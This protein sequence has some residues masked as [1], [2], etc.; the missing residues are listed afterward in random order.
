MYK[1]TFD[2]HSI[3]ETNSYSCMMDGWPWTHFKHVTKQNSC[4]ENCIINLMDVT[5]GFSQHT[6]KHLLTSNLNKFL[7]ISLFVANDLLN[8]K[9]HLFLKSNDNFMNIFLARVHIEHFG[10]IHLKGIQAVQELKNC[11]PKFHIK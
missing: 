11:P 3:F 10:C 4:K 7:W 5:L 1:T 9:F 8:I 2:F 6:S